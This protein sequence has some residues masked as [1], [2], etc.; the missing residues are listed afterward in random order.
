MDF[1]FSRG[2]LEVLELHGWGDLQTEL[3]T[4]SKRG[5]WEEMGRL[6]DDD[7]LAAFAVVGEPKDIPAQIRERFEGVV[8]R[9]SFYLPYES[10]HGELTGLISE[11]KA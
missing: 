9:V 7:I 3:N 11:L 8:D 2:R 1:L 4:L 6:L 10:D 5:A